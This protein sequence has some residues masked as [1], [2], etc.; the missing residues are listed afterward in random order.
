MSPKKRK[1]VIFCVRKE[2]IGI[3]EFSMR[4]K[5]DRVMALLLRMKDCLVMIMLARVTV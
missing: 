3:E 4:R 2:W 1:D 5:K